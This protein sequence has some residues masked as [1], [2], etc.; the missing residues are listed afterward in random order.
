MIEGARASGADLPT[1][2]DE[3]LARAAAGERLKD[4]AAAVADATGLGKRELYEAA[5]AVRRR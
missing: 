5:L 3:V 2:V 1:A 4:A